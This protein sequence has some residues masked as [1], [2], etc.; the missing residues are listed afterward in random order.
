MA[1][2][3]VQHPE[4]VAAY[5]CDGCD[6]LLCT[7]CIEESHALFLCRFCGERAMPLFAGQATSVKDLKKQRVLT[8]PYSL[9][10]ALTYPLR[11]S[12][13]AVY[14]ATLVVLAFFFVLKLSPVA[15]CTVY[16]YSLGFM[17][18]IIGLQFKIVRTTAEGENDLPN[19]PNFTDVWTL[20]QDILTW[21][22]IHSFV[23]GAVI[24]FA[25]EGV[26]RGALA[27]EPRLEFWLAFAL[28][29]WLSTAFMV[30]AYGAVGNYRRLKV[31]EFHNHVKGFITGGADAIKITN[32]VYA[33]A[34]AVFCVRF[35][36]EAVPIV[37]QALSGMLWL[38]WVFLVPHLS[39]L[40]FRW[41][42]EKMEEYYWSS[43]TG[44]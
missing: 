2:T 5:R 27:F 15:G 24:W 9:K 21:L 18:M 1:Q 44:V 30:M 42:T 35:L 32:I 29:L 43:F 4:V 19:W 12:G 20:V 6:K 41:H 39:G 33:G 3:C 23:Y 25:I 11:G 14:I 31:F 28:V 16:L 17:G 7:E 8:A 34:L 10:E 40:L 13:L 37:G 38:Y 26:S 36:L 22:V